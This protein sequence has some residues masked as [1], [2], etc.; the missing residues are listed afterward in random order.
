MSFIYIL[1]LTPHYKAESNWDEVSNRTIESHFLYLKSLHEKGLA[2]FVGRTD[3]ETDHAD[4]F[5]LCVL[6]TEQYKE[7]E[8]IMHN[9]P[10][11]KFGIMEGD[12]PPF[13]T[14]FSN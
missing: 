2:T 9:D 14:I 5:G 7:A 11:I 6:N 4:L 12:I 8:A 10:A 3:Y 1:R 13:N